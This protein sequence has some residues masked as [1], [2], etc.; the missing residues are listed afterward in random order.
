MPIGFDDRVDVPRGMEIFVRRFD[1]GTG[2]GI[3]YDYEQATLHRKPPVLQASPLAAN[4]TT[5]EFN[6]RQ[7]AFLMQVTTPAPE[8]VPAEAYAQAL[9]E[10]LGVP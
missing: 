4:Q 6:A 8:D 1:E 5:A 10:L 9:Q 2:L 3:A 7:Q